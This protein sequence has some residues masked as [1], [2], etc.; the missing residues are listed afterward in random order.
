MIKGIES[1]E[2]YTKIKMRPFTADILT[3]NIFQCFSK[4]YGKY[5]SKKYKT[6]YSYFKLDFY[7]T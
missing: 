1:S 5:K 2:N 7:I 6:Y 4:F 3:I